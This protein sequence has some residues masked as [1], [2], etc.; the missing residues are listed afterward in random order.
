MRAYSPVSFLSLPSMFLPFP[1]IIS[2]F[3][4]HLI[5]F[6]SFPFVFSCPSGVPL[7]SLSVRLIFLLVFLSCPFHSA[8]LS[9]Q[10]PSLFLQVIP[11]SLYVLSLFKIISN[12][13]ACSSEIMFIVLGSFHDLPC[14]FMLLFSSFT[15]SNV[16]S[17]RERPTQQMCR[18]TFEYSICEIEWKNQGL[19]MSGMS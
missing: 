16:L 5:L 17:L 6:P 10:F 18:V 8:L 2:L 14:P 12:F 13:R 1:S 3:C 4:V 15:S 19:V 7:I 9:R 11:F